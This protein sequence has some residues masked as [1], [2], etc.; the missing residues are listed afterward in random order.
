MVL[1]LRAPAINSTA[2]LRSPSSLATVHKK[3]RVAQKIISVLLQVSIV[4]TIIIEYIARIQTCR[5]T[6]EQVGPIDRLP[7]CPSAS[8]HQ[9]PTSSSDLLLIVLVDHPTLARLRRVV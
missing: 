9:V 1:I 7:K 2:A 5:V 4:S 8:L 6:S 3:T